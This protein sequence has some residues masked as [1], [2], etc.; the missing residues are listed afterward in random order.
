MRAQS[1]PHARL[2][3]AL[4]GPG[5]RAHTR[6]ACTSGRYRLAS[7]APG[8]AIGDLGG[9]MIQVDRVATRRRRWRA[10]GAADYGDFGQLATAGAVASTYTEV[11]GH[12]RRCSTAVCPTSP[13]IYRQLGETPSYAREVRA[14]PTRQHRSRRIELTSDEKLP[15]GPEVLRE[16]ILCAREELKLPARR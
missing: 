8:M 12:T 4:V 14:A 10:A 6:T 2:E 7:P 13:D 11:H 1:V 3:N 16:L 9:S 15:A 5:G